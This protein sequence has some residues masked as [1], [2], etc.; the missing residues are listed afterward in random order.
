MT[1]SIRPNS[2]TAGAASHVVRRRYLIDPKR[3]LRTVFVT[4]STA[5]VLVLLI[6]LAFGLLR[7][8]QGSFLAAVS[9]RLEP[10]VERQETTFLMVMVIFSALVVVGVAVRTVVE[11][12]RTAGAVFAVRQR[13]ERVAAGD[14]FV[15]L[16]LRRK[17]NLAELQEPFNAM[18]ERLRR[19]ADDEAKALRGLADRLSTMGNDAR[20]VADEL[21]EMAES[22][23]VGGTSPRSRTPA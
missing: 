1:D 19:T 18:V 23:R 13:M 15:R 22:K 21:R 8:N 16:R 4:T 3:Q 20:I 10:I 6:N 17:D 12:H 7:S 5:A 14:L 11:T 9:P 2:L